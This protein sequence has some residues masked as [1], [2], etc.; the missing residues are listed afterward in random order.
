VLFKFSFPGTG[1]GEPAK[2]NSPSSANSAKRL[3]MSEKSSRAEWFVTTRWS[4]VLGARATDS[5]QARA[6]LETLCRTYW[7]PL[8]AFVR[9]S[10][11]S[12]HDAEDLVQSFF[13]QCL[14]KD[15]LS[16]AERERGRFR[17]F[18]LLALKRF[19]AN[20]WDRAHARKRGGDQLISLDALT[21]EQRYATEPADSLSADK[22]Y[23]RRWAL[24]LLEKVL[25]Q[26]RSEQE[27]AGRLDTFN[28][29]LPFLTSSGRGTPYAELGARLG[30]SE[31]AVKVAVHRLRQRYREL[32]QQEIA[33]TV[34][35]PDDIDEE[36]RY[37]FRI[38]GA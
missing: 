14:E 29:L 31:G 12:P 24:T 33:D 19:L 8:Y 34:S 5:K 13:A 25:A 4:V 23:E 15:Y 38:L 20:E 9:R 32:L 2:A 11:R 3:G 22:L 30:I 37:L 28:A 35:S 18:L 16:A 17:S 21:A 27:A 1:E 36:R 26:L 7:Y 10:G 6:A